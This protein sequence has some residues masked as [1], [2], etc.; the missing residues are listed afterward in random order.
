[1]R[2]PLLPG[3]QHLCVFYCQNSCQNDNIGIMIAM[4]PQKSYSVTQVAEAVGR[5]PLRVRQICTKLNLGQ[6]L[7][8]R[9]RILSEAD[10]RM[11]R[12]C[13]KTARVGRPPKKF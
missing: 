5:T 10:V 6:M 9:M 1:M 7:S 3:F 4:K 8:N 2:L 13:I 12:D 11:I